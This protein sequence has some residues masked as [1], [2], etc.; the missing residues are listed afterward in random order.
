MYQGKS[1][2]SKFICSSLG[3]IQF[4]PYICQGKPCKSSQSSALRKIPW[5]HV[6]SGPVAHSAAVESLVSVSLPAVSCIKHI[7]MM[8]L[9]VGCFC[10]YCVGEVVHRRPLLVQGSVLY[11]EVC[12]LIV[13]WDLWHFTGSKCAWNQKARNIQKVISTIPTVSP[14]HLSNCETWG[15][16]M[17]LC[18]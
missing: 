2:P 6:E 17:P 7:G 9:Y 10:R 12:C 4:S 1:R 8:H 18:P 14:A 15:T 5:L 13:N 3:F 16:A 11:L